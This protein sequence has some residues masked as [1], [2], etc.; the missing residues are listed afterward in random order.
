[1]ESQKKTHTLEVSLPK[2]LKLSSKEITNQGIEKSLKRFSHEDYRNQEKKLRDIIGLSNGDDD[3][4][5]N[6]YL[7]REKEVKEEKKRERSLDREQKRRQF[8]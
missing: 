2:I 6:A 8:L 4:L 5:I 7:H 3:R 1:M